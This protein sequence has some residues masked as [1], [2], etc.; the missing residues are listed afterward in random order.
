MENVIEYKMFSVHH[1]YEIFLN[2][3]RI[4]RDIIINVEMFNPSQS[5]DTIW[6]HTFNSVLHKL[7]FWGAEKG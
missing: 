3:R 1:S 6:H 4:Q 2:L 7:H 5:R